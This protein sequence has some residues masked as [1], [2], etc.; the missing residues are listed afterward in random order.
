MDPAYIAIVVA[1]SAVLVTAVSAVRVIAEYQRG[2]V[3]RLGRR[4]PVLEPGLRLVLP[5]GLDTLVRV[6]LRSS[7]IQVPSHEV[8]THDGVPVQVSATVHMQVVNP[9][10]A[11]TRVVDYRKSAAQMVQAGLREVIAGTRLR[12]LLL[13]QERLRAALVAFVETRSEPWGVRVTAIDLRD[14]QLP[15]AM[16]R[17]MARQAEARGDRQAHHLQAEAEV[18][19]AQRLAAAAKILEGQPHAVQL[20]FIQALTEMAQ[21]SSTVVVVPLPL[22]LVQPFIDLQGSASPGRTA[23]SETGGAPPAEAGDSRARPD[24]G[25]SARARAPRD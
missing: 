11:V 12:E 17:A 6:D 16:Q 20:R 23:P 4:G 22:D 13:E 9:V 1:A 5:F 10:L 21:G 3:L 7:V 14:V 8:I 19:A 18:E 25:T 2:V 24:G 15:Q